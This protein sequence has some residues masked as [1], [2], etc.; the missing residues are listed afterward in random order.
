MLKM[1]DKRPDVDTLFW[2][3]IASKN[4]RPNF[5]KFQLKDVF[6]VPEHVPCLLAMLAIDNFL[7]VIAY[8][9]NILDF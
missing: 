3:T 9:D 4:W 1:W 5:K 6:K 8:V 7:H 2:Y